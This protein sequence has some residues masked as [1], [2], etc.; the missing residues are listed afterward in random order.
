MERIQSQERQS[1][2][3]MGMK[4][5]ESKAKMAAQQQTEGVRM[6]ID[7]AK[8]QHQLKQQERQQQRQQPTKEQ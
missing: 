4:A 8:T 3:Q 6:G 2:A 5:Q 7:V 1:G